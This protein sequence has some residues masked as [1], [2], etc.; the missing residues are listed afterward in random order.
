LSVGSLSL[1]AKGAERTDPADGRA[2]A[3]HEAPAVTLEDA[4]SRIFERLRLP[5]YR[6]LCASFGSPSRAE[7]VAQEAFLRLYQALRRGERIRSERAWVFRVAHNLALNLIRG[8]R[9]LEPLDEVG[10]EQLVGGREDPDPGPEQ[11]L[12]ERERM[13]RLRSGLVQLSRQQRQCLLL[14]VEGLRYREIAE[15]LGVNTSTVAEF[16]RRGVRKLMKEVHG[17]D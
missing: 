11:G 5:V 12:I 15:I 16:L 13:A 7:D 17:S 10:W 1:T 4:V 2:E 9:F 8:D 3:V 14:R 6:Y